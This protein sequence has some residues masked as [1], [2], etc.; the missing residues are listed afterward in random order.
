[1][2]VVYPLEGDG[3]TSPTIC[4]VSERNLSTRMRQ[5]RSEFTGVARLLSGARR[6]TPWGCG[7]RSSTGRGVQH[8]RPVRAVRWGV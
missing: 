6:S 7:P 3:A 1:V 8:P 5:W 2:A 4:G